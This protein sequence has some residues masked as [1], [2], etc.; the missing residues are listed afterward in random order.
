[1]V[2]KLATYLVLPVLIG[3]LLFLFGFSSD[4]NM[5]KKVKNIEVEFE[6][7]NNHFLTH[8]SV[9]KLL[10]QSGD[11]VQNRLKSSVD[12]HR[13]E[14][15]VSSSPFVEKS[16]VSLTLEGVL[17]AHIK[18]RKPLV[19]IISKKGVYYV[20]KFGVKMPL[21]ANFSAR[22]PLV[23]GVN[24]SE[25]IEE[26]TKLVLAISKEDFL[27]KEI[28]G[29]QRTAKN[30]YVFKVRSGDYV[31]DFGDFSKVAIKFVKLKAFYNKTLSN[32]SIKK[33]KRINVK[34]HKQVVCEKES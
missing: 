9:N 12:L 30:E 17:K 21:S 27:R 7:E 10:I 19:R 31:I 25:E 16:S 28:I 3:F 2:K 4:R 11:S 32:N 26:L 34:Y 33:Y 5:R 20:D 24:S 14:S 13:M 1:M 23:T 6:A 22:V 8:E 18:Q 15:V 29:I